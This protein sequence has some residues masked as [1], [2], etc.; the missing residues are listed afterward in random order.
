MLKSSGEFLGLEKLGGKAL[1]KGIV[2]ELDGAKVVP[3][4]SSRMP[5]NCFFLLA[6]MDA[7]TSPVKLDEY[8]VH[9]NPPGISGAL[10]E[11]RLYFDAFVLDAK[12]D[13]VYAAVLTSSAVAKPSANPASGA[14]VTPGTTT[15]AL[16]CATSGAAIIYTTD[17]TDPRFSDTRAT[18]SAP[19]ATTGWVNGTVLKAHA[20]KAGL[21]SSD[22]LT[23]TY[24]V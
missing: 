7:T 21:Y 3:V 1:A 5:A 16:S 17:G 15:V 20:A 22:V 4:A 13:G 14:S 19:I 9:E 18:Y 24:K 10:V 6:H 2:G 12:K 23:A 11:G 8:K